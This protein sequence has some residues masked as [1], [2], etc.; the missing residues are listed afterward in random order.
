MTK[1][2]GQ[3]YWELIYNKNNKNGYRIGGQT[4]TLLLLESSKFIVGLF[5][6]ILK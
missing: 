4:R 1:Y 3:Y 5:L 6:K 2:K